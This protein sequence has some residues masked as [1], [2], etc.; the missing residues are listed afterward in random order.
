VKLRLIVHS[1]DCLNALVAATGIDYDAR[2]DGILYYFR[3]REGLAAADRHMQILRDQGLTLERVERDRMLELEP[4]MARAPEVAGGIY[5]PDCQT[6][7][8]HKFANNLADWCAANR[9][10][11]LYYDAPIRRLVVEGD[12]IVKAQ[13]DRGEVVADAFVLAAGAESV[14]LAQ[15]VGIRLPIYPVKGVSITAPLRRPQDGPRMG[16]VDEDRLV[17][18]SSLGDQLR[19]ASSAVFG[20]FDY[21]H[22]PEDFRTILELTRSLYGDAVDYDRAVFWT[23][24]R[25]MT[26]SSVPIL[27]PTRYRNLHLNVGHGHVG[28]SMACGSGELVADLIAGRA[29]RIET[30]G[31]LAA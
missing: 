10:S 29:P 8:S 9:G 24:L 6:G 16:L 13:T 2:R 28:W 17:A 1:K 22:R 23:G 5:S 18:M 20:G 26:P 11:T 15:E 7:N 19:A 4:V 31:L 14:L 27:G 3:S 21:G 30:R 12:R 25:P